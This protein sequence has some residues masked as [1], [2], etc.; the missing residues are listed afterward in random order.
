MKGFHESHALGFVQQEPGCFNGRSRQNYMQKNI[1]HFILLSNLPI[2]TAMDS[3]FDS[4]LADLIDKGLVSASLNACGERTYKLT[5][6]GMAATEYL[7]RDNTDVGM[8]TNHCFD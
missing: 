6:D 8:Y 1:Q 2:T 5:A 3:T 7:M 4:Q